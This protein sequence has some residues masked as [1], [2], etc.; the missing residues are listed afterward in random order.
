M[1]LDEIK[2][3]L[4]TNL[5]VVADRYWPAFEG[6]AQAEIVGWIEQ[7]ARGNTRAATAAIMAKLPTSAL[8]DRAAAILSDWDRLNADNAERVAAV[9][10]AGAA[11]LKGV[12]LPLALAAVGF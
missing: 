10:A 12:L 8:D 2:R 9:G 4:G 3:R 6:M 7:V 5:A 1:T 11:L